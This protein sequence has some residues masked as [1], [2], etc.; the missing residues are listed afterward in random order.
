METLDK[1]AWPYPHLDKLYQENPA[2][3]HETNQEIYW[4]QLECLSPAMQKYGAFMVGE[5]WK[6]N[7]RGIPIYATFVELQ[8]RYF[9]KYDAITNF[10]YA[11]YK[12]E[13]VSQFEL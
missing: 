1:N 11:K 2:L 10:S 8:G 13:I 3:W 7:E 6:H 9:G 12:Q 5:P 4:D